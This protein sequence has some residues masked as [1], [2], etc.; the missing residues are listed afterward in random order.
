MKYL[1]ILLLIIVVSCNK[2]DITIEKRQVT[3]INTRYFKLQD[4]SIV[5]HS[6]YDASQGFVDLDKYS[7]P[8]K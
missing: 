4:F 7:H 1:I 2:D 5:Q 8:I 3:A 6:I